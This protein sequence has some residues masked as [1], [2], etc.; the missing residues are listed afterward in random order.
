MTAPAPLRG[1]DVVV[2]AAA[3]LLELDA[4][5]ED[6]AEADDMEAEADEDMADDADEADRD[7]EED[8]LEAELAEEAELRD[9]DEEAEDA[10]VPVDDGK[11]VMVPVAPVIEKLVEKL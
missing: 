10:A 4:A 8:T 11:P 5:R 6:D 9:A 1:A 2:V 7:A 3:E